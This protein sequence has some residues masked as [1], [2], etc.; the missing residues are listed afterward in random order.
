MLKQK[1]VYDAGKET[2]TRASEKQLKNFSRE[3]LKRNYSDKNHSLADEQHWHRHHFLTQC[4]GF[5]TCHGTWI[6]RLETINILNS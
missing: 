4:F 1:G 2:F 5:A 3:R 6:V